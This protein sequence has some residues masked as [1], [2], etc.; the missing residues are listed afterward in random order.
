MK[1]KFEYFDFSASSGGWRFPD[2]REDIRK[3]VGEEIRKKAEVEWKRAEREREERE[4]EEWEKAQTGKA[5]LEK[6]N[7]R[8]KIE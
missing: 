8:D 5:E 7:G 1:L 4:Q 2:M 3:S 6:V